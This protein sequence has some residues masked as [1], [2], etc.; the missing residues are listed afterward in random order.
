[1]S[2]QYVLRAADERLVTN[3]T[4]NGASLT[5]NTALCYVWESKEKAESERVVYQAI[6]GASLSVEIHVRTL[7]L[8]V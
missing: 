2:T 1:M 8:R 4:Q 5:K 3:D 7:M 6:L